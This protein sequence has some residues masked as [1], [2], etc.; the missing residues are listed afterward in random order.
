MSHVTTAF[1]CRWCA[2][3]HHR[4]VQDW[5]LLSLH[6]N[7]RKQHLFHIAFQEGEL[8][9][10]HFS[11]LLSLFINAFPTVC[12]LLSFTCFLT[13]VQMYCSR[14]SPVGSHENM[15][16]AP[17]QRPARL[18]WNSKNLLQILHIIMTTLLCYMDPRGA[19]YPRYCGF[20]GGQSCRKPRFGGERVDGPVEP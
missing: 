9:S 13:D 11:K 10:Q 8:V 18:T 15:C 16:L 17:G 14:R 5:C 19:L 2:H 12:R 3:L 4:F 6:V 7:L 1:P 20:A